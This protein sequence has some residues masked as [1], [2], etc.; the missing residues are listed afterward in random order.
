MSE[1][2]TTYV[3]IVDDNPAS[4]LACEKVVG[5]VLHCFP[6]SFTQPS[7]ALAWA[8]EHL[9]ALLIVDFRMPEMDGLQFIREFR[10]IPNRSAVPCIMLTGIREPSVRQEA[11]KLGVI[12]FLTKPTS[13]ERL[14][15]HVGKALGN[16]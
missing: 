9:P 4:A 2:Q 1:A 6:K 11:M 5:K 16:T 14:M 8:R 12:D 10:A 15:A 13:V 3:L 7:E